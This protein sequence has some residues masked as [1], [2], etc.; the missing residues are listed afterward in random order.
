MLGATQRMT[1]LGQL[2][3]ELTVRPAPT[4]QL[5]RA[6]EGFVQRRALA[7]PGF[8]VGGGTWTPMA[9]V[10]PPNPPNPPDR[11]EPPLTQP[12]NRATDPARLPAPA[13]RPSAKARAWVAQISARNQ[14]KRARPAG[15][16]EQPDPTPPTPKRQKGAGSGQKGAGS[17]QK[18]SGGS[19]GDRYGFE[20]DS[21]EV[22]EA[23]NQ[24]GDEVGHGGREQRG[25]VADYV[26]NQRQE[27]SRSPERDPTPEGEAPPDPAPPDR[28]PAVAALVA[29]VM[30]GVGQVWA[31]H[32][33]RDWDAWCLL[34]SGPSGCWVEGPARRK[35][36][37]RVMWGTGEVEE[38]RANQLVLVGED[39]AEGDVGLDWDGQPLTGGES[40]VVCAQHRAL[41]AWLALQADQILLEMR[42]ALQVQK[43]HRAFWQLEAAARRQAQEKEQNRL[44]EEASAV[45]REQAEAVEADEDEDE[46]EG[47]G[48]EGVGGEE[49]SQAPPFGGM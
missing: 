42:R 9:L 25:R 14:A 20:S 28:A 10:D 37:V 41:R 19:K 29:A 45:A 33:A 34:D 26:R 16:D 21:D 39:G 36:W 8:G 5:L 13:P 11:M 49:G 3:R 46:Q 38:Y 15:P 48:E 1:V 30:A 17:G 22:D 7:L 23:G 47:A 4:L 6:L 32:R 12:Y 27:P 24:G 31:G 43:D 40:P 2:W 35:G 18:G 44:A